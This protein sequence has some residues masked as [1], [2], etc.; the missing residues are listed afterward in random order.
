MYNGNIYI[1]S[2]FGINWNNN[3][4]AP[5]TTWQG[6]SLSANG[7]LQTAITD[8]NGIWISSDSGSTWFKSSASNFPWNDI[9]IS[10]DGTHQSAVYSVG[11]IWISSV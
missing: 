2:D 10:A 9:S 1:S 7:V 6:I 3:T 8:N 5:T 4:S 11:R